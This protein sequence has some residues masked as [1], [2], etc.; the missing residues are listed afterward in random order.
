MI[1]IDFRKKCIISLFLIVYY[2]FW[3]T[4]TPITSVGPS[5]AQR[6]THL[7][8]PWS[9]NCVMQKKKYEI[10]T[11]PLPMPTSWLNQLPLESTME[12]GLSVSASFFPDLLNG[13]P[14]EHVSISP[15]LQQL[16][17]LQKTSLFVTKHQFYLQRRALLCEWR[18]LTPRPSFLLSEQT[19]AHFTKWDLLVKVPLPYRKSL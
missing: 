6:Y 14:V 12:I 17:C 4:M 19:I 18:H 2:K 5:I 7:T 9:T 16:I 15:Y 13:C 10:D 3:T 11:Y 8:L 1:R